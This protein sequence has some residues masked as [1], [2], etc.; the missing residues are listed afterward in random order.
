[1]SLLIRD[2]VERDIPAI[3]ALLNVLNLAEGID[4]QT[5]S[6]S[7]CVALFGEVREVALSALVAEVMDEVVGVLLYYPGY[8]TLSASVGYHLA[9]MV[10]AQTHRQSGIGTK[11]MQAL[12]ARALGEGKQWVSLTVLSRNAAAIG[13]YQALGMT[14]VEVD[15]YAMGQGALAALMRR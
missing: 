10:V 12:A 7:L 1:M 6:T 8:D 9:D 13:F 4:L 11:L 5:D 14:Q 15:F 2:A 3:A